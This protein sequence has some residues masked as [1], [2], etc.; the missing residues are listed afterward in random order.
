MQ[1]KQ[2]QSG[3]GTMEIMLL[4]ILVGFVVMCVMKMLPHYIDDGTVT[5]TLHE[6]H[7]DLSAK[8]VSEVSNSDIRGRLTKSFNLNSVSDEVIESL[9]V[10]RE[11]GEVLVIL[12]YEVREALF[13]N[14]D[15]VMRFKHEVDFAKAP[16]E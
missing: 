12:N 5:S 9:D 6:A 14:V 13:G 16:A 7:K 4:L 1:V 10:V 2:K 11:D 8:D 15:V 3:M